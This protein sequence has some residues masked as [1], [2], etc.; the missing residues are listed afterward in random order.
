MERHHKWNDLFKFS[1]INVKLWRN[2]YNQLKMFYRKW[3]GSES[4][5]FNL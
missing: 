5:K 2:E 4:F 1:I 3:K